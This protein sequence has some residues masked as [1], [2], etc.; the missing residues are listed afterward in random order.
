[1]IERRWAQVSGIEIINVVIQAGRPSIP[2][3]WAEITAGFGPGDA[4]VDGRTFRAASSE[5]TAYLN[6]RNQR[7]G[8]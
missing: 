8:G 3:E 6:E 2:G 7:G 5:L 4:V 1:M